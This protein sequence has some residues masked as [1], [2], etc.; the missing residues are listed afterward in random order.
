MFI[1]GHN[2]PEYF[3][4]KLSEDERVM[5]ETL[6]IKYHKEQGILSKDLLEGESLLLISSIQYGKTNEEETGGSQ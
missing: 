4:D 2:I 1:C 5:L 3:W 6:N